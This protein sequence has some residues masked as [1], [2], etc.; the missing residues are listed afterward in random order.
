MSNCNTKNCCFHGID[1][2]VKCYDPQPEFKDFT[3]PTFWFN[4]CNGKLFLLKEI[5][6]DGK[7]VWIDITSGGS[8]GSG[9]EQILT[10]CGLVQPDSE[11]Q[12][13]VK[14]SCGIRA[15]AEGCEEMCIDI[16]TGFGLKGGGNVCAG[17]SL[18][19][20]LDADIAGGLKAITTPCGDIT[21]IDGKVKI[22]PSADFELTCTG[23]ELLIALKTP[24]SPT[25]GGTGIIEYS[26]GDVLVGKT[27]GT[28]EKL[29]QGNPGQVLGINPSGNLAYITPSIVPGTSKVVAASARLAWQA[30][31]PWQTNVQMPVGGVGGVALIKLRDQ[32]G[33]NFDATNLI[34]G[35]GTPLNYLRYIAPY[36]GMLAITYRFTFEVNNLDSLTYL[37]TW[38]IYGDPNDFTNKRFLVDFDCFA[39]DKRKTTSGTTIIPIQAGEFASISVNVSREPADPGLTAKMISFWGGDMGDGCDSCLTFSYTQFGNTKR[40]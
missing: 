30:E 14:G 20:E 9:I 29:P 28:L 19:I 17:E 35:D 27:D 11:G 37:Q 16:L 2:V 25:I 10:E 36:D 32:D 24:L 13:K 3:V 34:L 6:A 1:L 39:V 22:T 12:I 4:R 21:P 7:A 15:L 40:P 33:D 8:G 31:V 26:K 38:A 23:N 5:D 18:T